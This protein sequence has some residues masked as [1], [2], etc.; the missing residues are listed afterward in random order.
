MLGA[1]RAATRSVRFA[2]P[3]LSSSSDCEC[4][5]ISCFHT[6]QYAIISSSVQG[7]WFCVFDSIT[8][9]VLITIGVFEQAFVDAGACKESVDR[10][11]R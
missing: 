7:Q 3:S 11:V 5:P 6:H 9:D 1:R 8:G 4:T 10:G 2:E